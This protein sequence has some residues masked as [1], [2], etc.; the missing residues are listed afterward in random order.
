MIPLLVYL[1]VDVREPGKT[2]SDVGSFTSTATLILLVAAGLWLAAYLIGPGKR[3]GF[4]LGAALLAIWLVAVVQIVD[5]P[6]SQL[7]GRAQSFT[8]VG[9]V[10]PGLDDPSFDDPGFDPSANDPTFADPTF[11]GPGFDDP[12]ATSYGPENPSTELGIVSLL[13]GGT[14]PAPS[15]WDGPDP[16]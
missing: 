3:Y 7:F 6:L 16:G 10:S 8:S 2:I 1:F 9:P 5:A 4:Y 14:Y 12:S 13:F 11:Q 15:P